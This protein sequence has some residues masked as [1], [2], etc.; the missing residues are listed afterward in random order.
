M[1]LYRGRLVVVV[2][3]TASGRHRARLTELKR[4]MTEMAMRVNTALMD[5]WETSSVP[6][7][8]HH[9]EMLETLTKM[10]KKHFYIMI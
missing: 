8:H 6:G 10:Q 1:K 7:T 4:R 2:V 5:K 3:V 9:Q